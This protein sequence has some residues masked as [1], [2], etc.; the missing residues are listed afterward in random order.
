MKLPKIKE[1]QLWES[2]S[3]GQ[4]IKIIKIESTWRI[5]V[6]I[7]MKDKKLITEQDD[8]YGEKVTNKYIIQEEYELIK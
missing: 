8:E 7:I 5:I 4:T 3:R 2:K 6:S 1:E